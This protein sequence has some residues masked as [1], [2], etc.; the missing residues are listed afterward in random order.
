MGANMRDF[1]RILS[2]AAISIAG[3]AGLVLIGLAYLTE[4]FDGTIDHPDADESM[5]A[6]DCITDTACKNPATLIKL[7]QAMAGGNESERELSRQLLTRAIEEDALRPLAWAL[8]SYIDTKDAGQV[9][10]S[11]IAALQR[12]IEIC[13]LCDNQDLLRWRL[14]FVIRHW[15]S[16]PED[17]RLAVI[18]GADLLRWRY[19]DTDFLEEQ[20]LYALRHAVPY[21]ETLEALDSPEIPRPSFTLTR[22]RWCRHRCRSFLAALRFFAGKARCHNS[23]RVYEARAGRMRVSQN[24]R[25]PESNPQ[26]IDP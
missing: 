18:E 6:Q 1:T 9:T 24:L 17:L 25:L 22:A 13:R 26:R 21:A 15:D 19:E 14:E 23:W 11:A 20:D 7:A 2:A 8:M 3:L 12:S 5:I 10:P 16:I 4:R